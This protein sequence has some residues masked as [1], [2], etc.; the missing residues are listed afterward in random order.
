MIYL[1]RLDSKRSFMFI[2]RNVKKVGDKTYITPLLV[3]SIKRKGKKNSEHET[4]SNLSKWPEALVIEFEKLLKGGKVYNLDQFS[5][6]QGKFCGGLLVLSEICKRIGITKALGQSEKAKTA[7]L[8]IIGRILAQGSRLHLVKSWSPDQAIEDVLDIKDFDEDDL[9]ETMDWLSDNQEKFEKNLFKSKNKQE[10]ASELFL[11]DVTS[12]YF[13]GTENELS[14]FGYNRDKKKGKKQIVIGLLCDTEGYPVSVK[15]FKGNTQ[16]PKTVYDQLKTLK[17]VFGV[18]R[19]VLVGDRGMIKK[20]EIE[21]INEFEWNYITAITKPQIETLLKGE[22]LQLN[23]FDE[24]VMEVEYEGCRYIYRRNPVRVKEIKDNRES[25]IN[26][27]RELTTKKNTYLATHQKAT[28]PAALKEINKKIN[29][30][31]LKN[32]LSCVETGRKITINVDQEE[33]ANKARL[34]GCYVLKTDA[35]EMP[36]ETIHERYKALAEVEIAFRTFKTSLEEVRP[37]F[38]RKERRTRGHVFVCMLAYMVVKYIWDKTKELGYTRE[39][40][41]KTL[42]SIQYIN[43]SVEGVNLKLLPKNYQEHQQA[44]LD[45]LKIKLPVNL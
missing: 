10:T 17:E 31:K 9:S 13:E 37:I 12:S 16:D 26:S 24:K 30:L 8:L 33:L 35:F 25:K 6:D 45:K 15:V 14:D 22:I 7:L 36:K 28:V 3:R 1:N 34:D 32:I 23:L 18:N 21:K 2:K 4:I 41:L 20:A 19:V 11:Y 29:K 27:I 38:V 43:F 40:I 5:H 39:F 44:I 42:D